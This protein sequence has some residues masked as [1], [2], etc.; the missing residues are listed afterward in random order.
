M[1]PAGRLTGAFDG[2]PVVLDADDSTFTL[3]VAGLRS[4]WRL[5]TFAGAFTP[6]PGSLRRARVAVRLD[7]AGLVSLHVLP[8][9]WPLVRW[10]VQALTQLN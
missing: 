10:L 5:R 1:I 4:A 7:V 6:A 2:H 9:P 8:A 3:S